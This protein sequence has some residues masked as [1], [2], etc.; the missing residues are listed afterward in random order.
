[1]SGAALHR[2]LLCAGIPTLQLV[3]RRRHRGKDNCNGI[4]V[5][6]AHR[7]ILVAA[8]RRSGGHP[9]LRGQRSR[10]SLDRRVPATKWPPAGSTPRDAL[11]TRARRPA[12]VRRRRFWWPRQ[13][14]SMAT[15]VTKFWTKTS[16]PGTGFLADLCRAMGSGR[17]ARGSGGHPRSAS[18]FWRGAGAGHAARWGRCCR[19][20]ALAWE[21]AR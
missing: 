18:A 6:T 2:A 19:C 13:L 4:L 14:A 20:F 11:A 8:G 10:S 21:A 7:K 3:R 15:A 16:P 9:S 5:A 17:R 1:M 12:S